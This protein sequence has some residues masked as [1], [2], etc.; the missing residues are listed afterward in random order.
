[1]I[2]KN[3][4]VIRLNEPVVYL[5]TTASRSVDSIDPPPSMVRGL[6]TLNLTKPIRISHIQI[7]LLGESTDSWLEG[8]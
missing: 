7:T 4:L 3:T 2:T 6:L 5:Q 8:V 1:M